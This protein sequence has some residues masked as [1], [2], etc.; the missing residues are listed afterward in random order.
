MPDGSLSYGN[1]YRFAPDNLDIYFDIERILRWNGG[2]PM[3][4]L[5]HSR[6][7]IVFVVKKPGNYPVCES[8]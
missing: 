1:H 6:H 3:D 7:H 5:M 4:L 8:G 2:E